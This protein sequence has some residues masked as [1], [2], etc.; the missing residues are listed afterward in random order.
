[1]HSA[2]KFSFSFWINCGIGVVITPNCSQP[3]I[4]SYP[5]AT[6]KQR[7]QPS[8][9]CKLRHK[10]NLSQHS[11]KLRI[12]QQ[13]ALPCNLCEFFYTNK[14]RHEY[15]RE[16]YLL[17]NIRLLLF[18]PCTTLRG[19]KFRRTSRSIPPPTWYTNL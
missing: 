11:L 8:V 5:L 12:I 18:P 7:C 17:R 19:K 16:L 10:A 6:L 3:T 1:M 2:V 15:L 4:L 13:R 9:T 14:F